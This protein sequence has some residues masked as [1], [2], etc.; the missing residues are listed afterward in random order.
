MKENLRSKLSVI[1]FIHISSKFLKGNNQTLIRIRLNQE[2]K[3]IN[4]GMQTAAE[5]NDPKKV[6]FNFSSHELSASEKTLLVKGLNLSIPP[7][8]LNY[9]DFL[10]PFETLFSQLLSSSSGQLSTASTDTVSCSI[11]TAALKCLN[12]YQPK[13]EQNLSLEEYEAL[14]S[15]INNDSIIIQKSDKGNSVV[16]I[17]KSDYIFRMEELL[18]DVFKFEKLDIQ[19]GQDYNFIINQELRISKALR[20]LRNNGA[21]TEHLYAELNP[22]GTQPSVMYGLS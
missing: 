12:S 9:A 22:T 17:N 1:D 6:I 7:K 19:P 10:Q 2:K 5:T 14:K 20:A 11:K 16:I 13:L 8:S 18:S 15:L 4:L 21:M 3:L